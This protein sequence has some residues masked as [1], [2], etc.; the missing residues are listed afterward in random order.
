MMVVG[1]GKKDREREHLYSQADEQDEEIASH[2]SVDS[3]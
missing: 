1:S 2:K 3:L